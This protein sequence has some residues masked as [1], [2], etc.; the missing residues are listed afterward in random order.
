MATKH[1]GGP[2]KPVFIKIS[3]SPVKYKRGYVNMSAKS[4]GHRSLAAAINDLGTKESPAGSNLQKYGAR[5]HENGVAWCGLAVA[6]WLAEGG[7]DISEKL[8]KKIG[9]VPT[10]VQMAKDKSNGMALIHPK[11]VRA[12]DWVAY[13]FDGGLADHVGM[14]E[15]WISQKAGTFT[16]IEG[17]TSLG[18]DS[19]GGEVMRRTRNIGQ[20]EAFGRKTVGKKS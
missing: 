3:S 12:G 16:A 8:A 15:A 1:S 9:Y 7:F 4:I 5:W 2:W 10:L 6:N 17:N 20:V 14:F 11:R 18:N 13:N 19:N